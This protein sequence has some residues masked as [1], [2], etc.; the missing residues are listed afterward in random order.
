MPLIP[1]RPFPASPSCPNEASLFAT[2]AGA[3]ETIFRMDF[4]LIEAD[5]SKSAIQESEWA[6]WTYSDKC[7]VE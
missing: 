3:C 6:P 1:K 2:D 7:I 5:Q 4:N